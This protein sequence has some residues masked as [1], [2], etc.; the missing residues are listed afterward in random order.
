MNK[1]I[2]DI[3]DEYSILYK[4]YLSGFIHNKYH[5]IV[6]KEYIAYFTYNSFYDL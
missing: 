4:F 5:K 2:E 3:N 6:S 1:D